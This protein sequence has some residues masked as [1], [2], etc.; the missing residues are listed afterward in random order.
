MPRTFKAIRRAWLIVNRGGVPD[1]FKTDRR[2]WLIMNRGGVP[3][4]FKTDRRAWLIV[5]RGGVFIHRRKAK[6]RQ[7]ARQNAPF[8][9][10]LFNSIPY[11]LY[12]QRCHAA[13]S[14]LG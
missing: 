4:V 8:A 9:V 11:R 2:A 1:V 12:E 3:D 14:V 13:P 7:T 5:N 10:F 6:K